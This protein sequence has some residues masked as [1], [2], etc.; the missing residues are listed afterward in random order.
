MRSIEI[1]LNHR[2]AL[3]YRRHDCSVVGSTPIRP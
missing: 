1:T 3:A 2:T